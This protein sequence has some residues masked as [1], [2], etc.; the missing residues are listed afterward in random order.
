MKQNT[1]KP[2]TPRN[3]RTVSAV[4]VGAV[5]TISL[6]AG[7][8]SAGAIVNGSTAEVTP[9][10]VSLQDDE[11]HFCGGSIVDAST[12][13]T[14][15][16]CLEG[17]SASDMTIRAGVS[18][19]TDNT[20]QDRKVTSLDSHPQYA[21][22]E[23]GDIAIVKLSTPLT[24][25]SNVQP[26]ALATPSD[27]RG[28]TTATVTG[29][30]AV[31][32]DG[33][34]SDVLLSADVPLVDD[35]TCSTQLGIDAMSELCAGGSGLDSCY[36][37]SGGPLVIRT[38]SGPRLAGVVSWG[39]ECGGPT[40][41]VY[42]EVPTYASFI[43]ERSESG[44][45]AT[46]P[47][48]TTEPTETNPEAQTEEREQAES[49]ETT[50]VDDLFALTED[51]LFDYL[52]SLTDDEFYDL[53]DNMSDEDYDD[54]FF[55]ESHESDADADWYDSDFEGDDEDLDPDHDDCDF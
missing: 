14:A 17:V 12:I 27:V 24:F 10:Q 42:A 5:A 54:L 44:P 35:T 13:V 43:N 11:G 45:T 15:A 32:E 38:E 55:G 30:G 29:W 9:W 21:R 18:N 22:N 7:T 34:S 20:G 2:N 46:V 51:E 31:S 6:F 1:N 40:P 25:N 16:H 49:G 28:A 52:D 26:I 39:E 23:V 3:R 19:A 41:G 33:E 4:A 8:G 48:E 37:D 53:I 36:G 47:T 50:S